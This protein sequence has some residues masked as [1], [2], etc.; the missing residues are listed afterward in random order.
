M[1]DDLDDSLAPHELPLHRS[2][3]PRTTSTSTTSHPSP[4]APLPYI[5]AFE[6][7]VRFLLDLLGQMGE[8]DDLVVEVRGG[9]CGMV[10]L[11]VRRWEFWGVW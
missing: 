1:L 7:S 9:W 3:P 5:Q 6:R 11:R 2:N 4:L 10:G 8:I